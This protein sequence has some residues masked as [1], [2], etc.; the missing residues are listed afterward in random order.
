[1]DV[2]SIDK[3]GEDF[4]L[5]YDTKGIPDLVA[6]DARTILYADPLNKVNTIQIILET[7]NL[8]MVTRGAH[9]GRI[10]VTTQRER[11]PGSFDMFNMKDANG[12]SFAT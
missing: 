3:T 12:N 4:R 7:G 6:H 8:C 11:N 5:I 10:G 1:M 2:I 9:L